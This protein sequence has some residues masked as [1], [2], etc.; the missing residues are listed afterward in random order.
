MGKLVLSNFV[1]LWDSM[2]GIVYKIQ[3]IIVFPPSS[4][5]FYNNLNLATR[6]ASIQSSSR[7]PLNTHPA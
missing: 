5:E 6:D 7:F 1:R 3:D 2:Q 4:E